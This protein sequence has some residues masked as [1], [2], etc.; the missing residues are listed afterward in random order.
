MKIQITAPSGVTLLTEKTYCPENIDVI[1]SL[2]DKTVTPG[3]AQ[4]ITPDTGY[5]GLSAVNVEAVDTEPGAATPSAAEQVITPPA[6]K[7]FDQFTVAATPTEQKTIDTN[8]TFTPS[9]GKFFDSVTVNVNTAKP[10]QEKS[11]ELT[12][13]DAVAVTPD[14]GYTLSKVTAMPKA[15]LAN[16]ADATAAA[17]DILSGKT[18]YVNG[19]K[20]T[21][22]LGTQTKTATPS[23][24]EQTIASDA[25]KLLSSVVV[26]AAPLDPAQ[27]VTAGTATKT[28][29]PN[30]GN[31]GIKS[32]T[33]NPT[34]SQ[35]KEV[36]LTAVGE[37]VTVTPDSGKL[38]SSVSI[39]QH[40]QAKIVTPTTSQQII[41]PD[42]G[43]CGLGTV[44]VNAVPTE[45]KTA[46][47]GT[48]ATTITPTSGK[49]LSAVTVNPTPTE[50]KTVTANGE[51]TPSAGKFL[52][53]VTVNVPSIVDVA[54]AAEMDA[55]LVAA[56]VGKI[57]RFTGTTDSTYTNG[58]LYEVVS[59]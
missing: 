26:E 48:S 45:E 31:I 52:S 28:V 2:Q 37:T 32:V 23:D 27:T 46:T 10:E 53:K 59:G 25:G 41:S 8:G 51:V 50:E 57:Y 36:T 19:S 7:F 55:K 47:A 49:F 3:E 13:M 17:G 12:T 11:V 33:V 15:P 4:T 35:A 43:F 30:I 1:P 21:G 58:D 16:T 29:S 14:A 56:N 40:L 5:A 6:G 38:L 34:P 22:V 44:S 9:D 54:T 39:S 20:I 24:V 18:A 42:T